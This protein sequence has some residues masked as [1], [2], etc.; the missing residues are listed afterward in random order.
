MADDIMRAIRIRSQKS[1][2]FKRDGYGKKKQLA[3]CWRRPRGLH[4]KQRIQKKAKGPLPT[5][6]YGS[7]LVARGLHP[8]G[9][10][11]VLVHNPAGLEG[12]DPER[13]A[14]RIAAGV[15]A[16]KRLLIQEMALK[17]GLKI[18]NPRETKPA[19][20]PAAQPAG[21]EEVEEEKGDE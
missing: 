19:G 7:P 16:K 18:L 13:D 2:R 17:A 21:G 20:E 10:R 12:L 9:Y 5:P 4:N 1:A 15:G 8:S 3:D 14:I 11:E 6:G